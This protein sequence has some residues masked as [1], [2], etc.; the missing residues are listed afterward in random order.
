[1]LDLCAKY[2]KLGF[3]GFKMKRLI[4]QLV[5]KLSSYLPRPLPVGMTEFNKFA[6]SILALSGKY[7]DEDSMKF[8]LAS[9]IIHADSKH[10]SLSKNYFVVRLR[11]VA[12]NQVASQ[13]FQDIKAKQAIAQQP[14]VVT[15]AK[16]EAAP[17][18]QASN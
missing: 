18:G 11:K 1:M 13:V 16:V 12:A 9:M 15:A 14:G 5:A 8:A 6:D 3:G 2:V 17:N 10:G 7:A 4:L